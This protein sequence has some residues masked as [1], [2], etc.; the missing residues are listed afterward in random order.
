MIRLFLLK[1]LNNTL[2]QN[3]PVSFFVLHL[4]EERMKVDA[5]IVFVQY[6]RYC[7]YNVN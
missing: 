2:L 1:R 4:S 7:F 5:L 3:L 6:R